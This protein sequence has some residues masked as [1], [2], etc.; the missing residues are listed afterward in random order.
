MTA[1]LCFTLLSWIN[2]SKHTLALIIGVFCIVACI[3]M[4]SFMFYFIGVIGAKQK[5]KLQ[6]NFKVFL[7][8]NYV[9]S[10][11][12][13]VG[14][15]YMLKVMD[16]DE[17]D[18]KKLFF[19]IIAGGLLAYYLLGTT[20]FAFIAGIVIHTFRI[21]WYNIDFFASILTSQ[22]FAKQPQEQA[23]TSM[24]SKQEPSNTEPLP[25]SPPHTSYPQVASKPRE[26]LVPQ[27]SPKLKSLKCYTKEYDPNMAVTA[28]LICENRFAVGE[29]V[30]GLRCS[31]NHVFHI[32]CLKQLQSENVKDRVK[33]PVC[34]RVNSI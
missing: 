3:A 21:L 8:C 34:K 20:M 16:D 9:I 31:V 19:Y 13:V 5:K 30:A 26:R 25:H 2:G 33:C 4:S 27:D 14:F 12:S 24:Q 18:N 7:W 23:D 28:C 29:Q 6:C 32:Q 17:Y 1:V 22:L 15:G 10:I 11:G